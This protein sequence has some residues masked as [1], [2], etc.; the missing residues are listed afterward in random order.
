MS[1]AAQA[2]PKSAAA[3]DPSKVQAD[4]AK[5]GMAP[6]MECFLTVLGIGLGGGFFTV[7]LA[8]A[9]TGAF[10]AL[11]G[12]ACFLAFCLFG[13]RLMALLLLAGGPRY[14]KTWAAIAA[15]RIGVSYLM[16]D[17]QGANYVVV[18][19]E[20]RLLAVNGDLLGFDDV[21]EIAWR[22]SDGNHAL[23][24]TLKS[25][26]NPVRTA[27]LGNEHNLKQAYA[28]LGNTLGFT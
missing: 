26:A 2:A 12:V 19:E 4:L 16:K 20:R 7:M 14:R 23:E 8:M 27:D 10:A 15:G 6:L 18:D 11:V 25:G 1:D 24:L 22:V 28:R 21:R 13:I 9:G 17:P 5:L 3:P